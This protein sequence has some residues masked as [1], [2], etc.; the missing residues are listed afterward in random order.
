[1]AD[2]TN[3][4]TFEHTT[5]RYE[6][7]E[8]NSIE[9]ISLAIKQGEFLVITGQSGCGKTTLTRCINNLIPCFFEG[10]LSGEVTVLGRSVKTSDAGE[11][12]K[13]IASVIQDPRSQFFTTNSSSEVAFSCENYGIPHK[14]IV[15][16]V[17]RAFRSMD[18]EELKDR[19]IFTLSSGERQKIAFIAA[20]ALDPKIYVLDE[21]SANLDIH[22]ILQVR[23]ILSKL[24]AAGHTIII[25]EHRLFYLRG[26]ADRYLI[27][28]DGRICE[29]LTAEE[30][31]SLSAKQIHDRGLRPSDLDMIRTKNK[32]PV[33]GQEVFLKVKDLSFSHKGM[34]NLLHGIS[35]EAHKGE[36]IALIG[37]NGCG[38]TTFGKIL[39]GLIR[40][41][42]GEFLIGG[43]I[44]K[45]RRLSDYVYFVMQEAD[46]QLY[47]ESVTQELRLGNKSIPDINKKTADVLKMLH[48]ENYKDRHP[49]ALSGGQ[50]QRLTIGAAILSEKPI[51]VLDEPT[52]GLDRENMCAVA[53]AVNYLRD[54]GKL[55]F[56]IT[57]DPEFISLTA[58][59]AQLLKNGEIKEDLPISGQEEFE[60]VKKYM[61]KELTE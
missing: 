46:H 57:H 38:K 8:H 31:E 30:A 12:G 32:E 56:I 54:R 44:V 21:P 48:L 27:M 19:D 55:V 16:R 17:D 9:D 51:I 10:E 3:I 59:R 28:K 15:R 11:A 50:K 35:F 49:Y 61:M 14:E 26:L 42:G 1:M 5:F 6:G 52:S 22:T 24:K 23:E 58:T 45:Q 13:D 60:R 4:I 47:T 18:M 53:D 36:T 34:P 43:K 7:Q 40:C 29:D 41:R 25:S 37:D 39:A 2:K 20:T 33:I